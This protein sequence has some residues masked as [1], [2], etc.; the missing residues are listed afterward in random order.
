MVSYG[1][2]I[3]TIHSQWLSSRHLPVVYL[4]TFSVLYIFLA[5]FV[6]CPHR[7][8]EYIHA[9]FPYTLFRCMPRI[10]TTKLHQN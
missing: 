1:F 9:L 8:H 5:I 4:L 6:F 3:L 10:T 2:T 7:R